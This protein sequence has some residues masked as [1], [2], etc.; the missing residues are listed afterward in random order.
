MKS[1][2]GTVNAFADLRFAGDKLEPARISTLLG[3]EPTTAYR[4]GEVYKRSRGHEVVGRTGIWLLSSEGY[5]QSADL[6]DHLAYLREV[7]FPAAGA[8]LVAPIK[9]LVRDDDLEADVSCFWYGEHGASPPVIPEEI[10][11]AFARIGA[12]IELDFDT[13]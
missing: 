6:V 12:T 10:R 4:K 3:I 2:A 8:N 7:I 1:K 11:A 13:D 5:V 9:M